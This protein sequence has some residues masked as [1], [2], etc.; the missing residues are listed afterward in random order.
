MA[1]LGAV[2]P[3]GAGAVDLESPDVSIVGESGVD[4]GAA[5]KGHAGSVEGALCDRVARS[6][7]ELNPFA[8]SGGQ[9]VGGES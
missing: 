1:N 4:T 9:A 3:D 2:E 7:S 6:E 5:G 8:L